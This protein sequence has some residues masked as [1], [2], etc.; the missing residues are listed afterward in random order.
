MKYRDL[1]EFIA[2]LEADGK[3]KRI[4]HPDVAAFGNDR[5]RRPRAARRGAGVAV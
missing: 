5:N 4:Q 3:L 1:R 2:G